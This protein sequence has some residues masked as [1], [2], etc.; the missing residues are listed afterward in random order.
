M[1]TNP[2]HEKTIQRIKYAEEIFNTAVYYFAAYMVFIYWLDMAFWV[3]LP[4][5]ILCFMF[6]VAMK[7]KEK[8][9][10]EQ[11]VTPFLKEEVSIIEKNEDHST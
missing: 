3:T 1:K 8:R 7:K 5:C 4:S 9:I 2:K 11:L 10:I 6:T